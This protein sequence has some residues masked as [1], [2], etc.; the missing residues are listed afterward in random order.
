[1]SPTAPRSFRVGPRTIQIGLGVLW[2]LD[3]ILQLQPKMF[4]AAFADQVIRPSANG[5]PGPVAWPIDEMARL[6]SV[7]PA[8]SNGIFASVQI[9]IGIGLFRR[10]TVRAALALSFVWACGVW[11]FGEGFGMLLTGTASPLS[12]AP[13]AV[14]LYALIGVLVWPGPVTKEYPGSSPSAVAQGPL[15]ELGG[16]VI[17]AAVW[18]GMSGLWLLPANA[19]PDGVG[20]ALTT[21]AGSSPTWLAHFQNSLGGALQGDGLAV[22]IVLALLSLGIGIGPLISRHATV[23]LIAGAALSLDYW[24]LGQSFGGIV[25][26]IATDPNSGPLFILLALALF[27]NGAATDLVSSPDPRLSRALAPAPVGSGGQSDLESVV[28]VSAAAWTV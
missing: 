14:L 26:G 1:M 25:T 11:C 8:T 17:W 2:L 18:L 27:P 28:P 23:F 6:V 15:G 19:G 13:G 9:L 21:A 16:R 12:G 10:D 7:H 20:N 5:Q 3:G 22:S 24:V 4:G